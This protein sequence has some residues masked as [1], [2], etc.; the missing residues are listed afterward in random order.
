MK[1]AKEIQKA[2]G[3]LSPDELAKFRAW[4]ETF[5]AAEFD[6]NV[7]RDARSRKLD[8]VADAGIATVKKK[9]RRAVVVR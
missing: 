6:R 3:E 1:T 7:E 9:A 5:D 4:F 2:I 8:P